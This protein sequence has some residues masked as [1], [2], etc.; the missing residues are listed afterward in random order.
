[1]SRPHPGERS[2]RRAAAGDESGSGT[3]IGVAI[4]FPMLLLVIV[5]LQGVS[6]ASRTEQMLQTAANRAA[7]TASLCCLHVGDASEAAQLIL[8]RRQYSPRGA[9]E[10]ANDVAGD[11]VVRFRNVSSAEVPALDPVTGDPNSVPSGGSVSVFVSCR[12]PPER[13]GVSSL[14][15]NAT[16]IA[17]GV[18]TLDPSRHRSM[19]LTP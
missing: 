17:V 6:Y 9:L 11:A 18:A 3:A 16:R 10:C 1:M 4:I 15:S 2:G 13:V 19:P 14:A 7:H 5:V 12:L 8:A